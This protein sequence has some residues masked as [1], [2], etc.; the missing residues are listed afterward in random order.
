M[1]VVAIKDTYY[2]INPND[3]K[4][5]ITK[6]KVYSVFIEYDTIRPCIIND[7]GESISVGLYLDVL[8]I[9]DGKGT[10]IHPPTSSSIDIV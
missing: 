8:K 10:I 1:Q 7:L 3:P 4:K 5:Y 2:R 9:C 6:D